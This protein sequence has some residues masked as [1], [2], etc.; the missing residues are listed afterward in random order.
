MQRKLIWLLLTLCVLCSL[1]I[2]WAAEQKNLLQNPSF[3]ELDNEGMPQGWHTG[4]YRTTEGYTT[5]SVTEEGR[6]GRAAV[7]NSFDLNDARFEQT[8]RVQPNTT[9][10]LTGYVKCS[11]VEEGGWGANLSVEGVYLE[12]DGAFGTDDDWRCLQIYGKTGPKQTE[13]K[14][15]ARVGGY[16]GESMGKAMFDDLS[17]TLVEHVPWTA[18]VEPWY[19]EET[20]VP[21]L[22]PVDDEEE[23]T[24]APFWPWLVTLSGVYLLLGMAA[25]L[26]CARLVKIPASVQR[27]G[28]PVFVLVGWVLAFLLRYVI[29]VL[30]DG[31]QV[32]VN[33]FTA[34]SNTMAAV[35][36][37]RF[38]QTSWC[39]YPPG[40]ALVLGVN[41]LTV[42]ALAGLFGTALPNWLRETIVIKCLPMLC[43]IGMA[44][45]VYAM[46]REKNMRREEA[47]LL[48]L[49]VAFCPVM[50]INSA[51][52]CQVD[53]VLALLLLAVVW[54]AVRR[55][56]AVLMPVY[57]L[58]VLMK[59]QALMVGPLGLIAV[60]REFVKVEAK[61]TTPEAQ[62]QE[63]VKP[64]FNTA[65]RL[66]IPE[67]WKAM[68]IGVG[69]AAV[70]ALAVMLPFMFGPSGFQWTH[71]G[72]NFWL[73]A[74]YGK[75]MTSYP[76]ATVNTANIYYIFDA[77]WQ[78]IEHQAS[79]NIIIMLEL[80]S[81]GWGAYTGLMNHRRKRMLWW[82][83]PAMMAIVTALYLFTVVSGASWSFVGGV[84]MAMAFMIVVPL[85]LRSGNM[86]VLPLMGGLLFL[87]L[88]NLG[89]MMHE[90]YLFPAM[91]LFAAAFVYRRD[92]RILVLLL[93]TSCTMFV[94]EGI[95]L[96]NSIRLGSAM[97]HLNYDDKTLSLILA[98]INLVT[99]PFG[100]W[101]G[102]DV[103][104]GRMLGY[105]AVKELQ[106]D[107][108]LEQGC[109]TD[110]R[111]N[112][113]RLDTILVLAVT[114]IYSAV[115]LWNL[116]STKA[117]QTTWTS[118]SAKEQV[119]IDLG[120]HYD[121]L[122]IA[123]FC[124]VSYN[125]FSIAVSDDMESWSDEYW[126]ELNEGDC[127]SWKYLKPCTTNGS[128][129]SYSGGMKLTE[130]QR[131]SGRYVRVTAQQIGL[132]L[133]ELIFRDA[134]G[135]SV[136][137][138]IVECSGQNEESPLFS[139]PSAI[140]DEPDSMEG[141][142]GW[143]NSTYFDEIYH[144]RTA[145]ELLDGASA[146]EWTHPP[147]G[148][149]IMSWMIA[150]FGMTPFG[151]RFGGALAGILM[152]PAMY[153]LAKQ[154]TKRTSLA[155]LA[156]TMMALDCMHLTQTRIA[157]IDSYPVLFIILSYLFMVRYMQRD[158]ITTPIRRLL[159]D[160]ALSGFF[161][162]CGIAS[163][164]IGVY[165]GAGLGVLFF[166]HCA[167]QI[168]LWRM[169]KQRV[170]AGSNEETVQLRAE[171]TWKRLLFICLWCVLFFVAVPVAI[172]VLSYIP[173]FAHAKPQGLGELLNL[174][175]QEQQ[176]MFDYHA[177]PGLGMDHAFYSPWYEWPF[178]KRPMYYAMASFMPRG[179]S[180]SI[181]CFGN[182]AVWYAGLAGMLV[183]LVYW[184][185]RHIY[186]IHG[187][188]TP[189]H[190]TAR[191][192]KPAPAIV[193]IGMLA[194][195]LP[196]V[197]VPRGTY[198][199]HFFASIPFMILAFTLVIGWILE[200]WPKVGRGILFGWLA[201]CL[202]VFIG[203]YPYASGMPAP[204]AWLDF[205]KQFLR[206]YY[207]R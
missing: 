84:A 144:A 82:A 159:P 27:K 95:V 147:L 100:L 185:K 165:S 194:Q 123:Y 103:C 169:A 59:P 16:S 5:F 101:T 20:Q 120:D 3:E 182:P 61:E 171:G 36:P 81:M 44:S 19:H 158:V 53:S 115:A 186:A 11:G 201:V 49:I 12:L 203:F 197:L 139:D 109:R 149:V 28:I 114:L 189:I 192:W 42:K 106:A 112:W 177:T 125:D 9:Y 88:Y 55:Q 191:D 80:A 172:Y 141:E 122:A 58:A 152:L 96:D 63:N 132:K 200:R 160:L 193:L 23:T 79:R 148:K 10:C 60:L 151:W 154:L 43:D 167:R 137:G 33:C 68:L 146:Y 128:V 140:I 40:Y 25:L 8:V 190:W 156:M 52:W 108:A 202:V 35:G 90:R 48:S 196:W 31:Y 183:L 91:I 205:M 78:P 22:D 66:V 1:D 161:M 89:T 170:Q 94:N 51:A 181:F 142:P 187:R 206:V 74:L 116:G 180:Q 17:L 71:D 98:W 104:N 97:G 72:E 134:D 37:G 47:G 39:D 13:L 179:Y 73:T 124:Q 83:E 50:V 174:I 138:K 118:S 143:Y 163:K 14:V 69:A 24:A 173:H 99:V 145:K 198:I 67:N 133:N 29:A 162:G 129:H 56:W 32:D 85:F 45:T 57:V 168:R 62:A 207:S 92:W 150:I 199:Y 21:S 155:F 65:I 117:P 46:G 87:L 102:Y 64:V 70:V 126:A 30:V 54:L 166:W 195:F 77:N 4:A 34:W 136:V 153:L 15:Y 107:L 38:Y 119:V 76:Y 93:V 164:W 110:H 176:R 111:L 105:P 121:D 204:Y 18:N 157:T 2:A 41:G 178:I 86:E 135:R 6:S 75:T 175:I 184:A 26:W 113:K 127:Y 188:I 7:V 130:L 131:V